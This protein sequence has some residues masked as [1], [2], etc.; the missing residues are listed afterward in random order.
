[1]G[2]CAVEIELVRTLHVLILMW[3]VVAQL[4]RLNFRGVIVPDLISG[5]TEI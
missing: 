2:L 5:M 1:M 3:S 4:V